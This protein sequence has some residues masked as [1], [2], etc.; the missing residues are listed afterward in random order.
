MRAPWAEPG[1]GRQFAKRYGLHWHDGLAIPVATRDSFGCP[2]ADWCPI[3]PRVPDHLLKSVVYLYP[4]ENEARKG[5]PAGSTAFFVTVFDAVGDVGI[6]YL[7]SC[8]HCIS[9]PNWVRMNPRP[10]RREPIITVVQARQWTVSAIDDLAVVRFQGPIYSPEADVTPFPVAMAMRKVECGPENYGIG[11][12]VFFI[13]RF[14]REGRE[15]TNVPTVRF[16]HVSAMPG[17][18]ISYE[19][20]GARYRQSCFLVE[21]CAIPGYSGSPA[22]VYRR[23]PTPGLKPVPGQVVPYAVPASRQSETFAEDTRLLGVVCASFPDA[24]I[25]LVVPAWRV[26]KLLNTPTLQAARRAEREA[27]KAAAKQRQCGTA[28]K[29]GASRGRSRPKRGSSALPPSPGSDESP[30]PAS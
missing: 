24:G 22:W 21:T 25:A 13:G 4:T 23:G 26:L 16:G 17:D 10:P 29:E 11:D 18:R 30:S 14:I 28:R 9:H 2:T 5:K 12:D 15:R 27:I 20:D 7:V 1:P 6:G 19:H 8:R 3:M